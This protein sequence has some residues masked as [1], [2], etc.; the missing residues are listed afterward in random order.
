MKF[1]Y[2]TEDVL[3]RVDYRDNSSQRDDHLY[4]SQPAGLKPKSE[5]ERVKYILYNNPGKDPINRK[6]SLPSHDDFEIIHV[7]EIS[8]VPDDEHDKQYIYGDRK[9]RY[10]AG[11][12]VN[13]GENGKNY[14]AH[15]LNGIEY[16]NTPSNLI[17]ICQKGDYTSS[18]AQAIH[19]V[20]HATGNIQVNNF[21]YTI[22]VKCWDANSESFLKKELEIK[23]TVR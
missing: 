22:P 12:L 5:W 4:I 19:R 3:Y 8:K 18:T 2:L 14:L 17:G 6:I 1:K 23:F 10:L 11:K 9:D 16:D 21:T 20:L 15:H 7:D 13:E